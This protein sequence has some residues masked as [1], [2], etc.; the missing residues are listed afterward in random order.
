MMAPMDTMAS[1]ASG[2]DLG[3]VFLG[4]V[5]TAGHCVGM[6]GG[7]I[8]AYAM[9]YA[10]GHGHLPLWHPLRLA[11]H[12]LYHTG[13]VGS[14]VLLGALA[15]WAGSLVEVTG[16]LVGLA[17]LVHLLAALVLFWFGLALL[18]LLPFKE[19]SW[20]G[21]GWLHGIM[22]RLLKGDSPWRVLPLG[23]FTGLI[24][25]NMHWAFQAKAAATGSPLEGMAVMLAF[26]LGTTGPL[27]LFGMMASL[28]GQ[29]MRRRFLLAAGVLILIMG[30]WELKQ[31]I[32]WMKV[33]L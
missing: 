9:S 19:G 10:A 7:L 14:Y 23:L 25:C 26:G 24:P 30:L 33:W 15:G 8:G 11:P 1:G 21:S 13:R 29:A 6:C 18:G 4:G 31:A 22:V 17:G 32:T 28:M 12:L 5:L 16:R 2:I 20:S 3:M 27:L